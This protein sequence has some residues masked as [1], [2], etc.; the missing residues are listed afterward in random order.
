MNSTQRL[1]LEDGKT[2]RDGEGRLIT[3]QCSYPGRPY[4][5]RCVAGPNINRR[6]SVHGEN[7]CHFSKYDLVAEA[8]DPTATS[9]ATIKRYSVLDRDVLIDAIKIGITTYLVLQDDAV[10]CCQ[11]REYTVEQ[12]SYIGE[13]DGWSNG[14]VTAQGL[15]AS[16]QAAIDFHH[17]M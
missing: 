4:P 5:F 1:T 16:I 7:D 6:Y 17:E 9:Y 15:A 13:Y 3:V 10:R 12:L 14:A 8:V 11:I 2:Y